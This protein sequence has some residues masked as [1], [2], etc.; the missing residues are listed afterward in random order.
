ML[1]NK[2]VVFVTSGDGKKKDPKDP[3]DENNQPNDKSEGSS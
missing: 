1:Y 2:K 3:P